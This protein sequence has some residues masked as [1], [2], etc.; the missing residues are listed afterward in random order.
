MLIVVFGAW[1]GLNKWYKNNL[2]P[3]SKTQSR[4]KVKVTPGLN[5]E[6]IGELL[7]K[8]GV[9]RSA[10]AFSWYTNGS[11]Q[12]NK[13]Q[14]GTY[15]FSPSQP[16]ETIADWLANGKTNIFNVII[17]P[18][19]TI[20]QL[21]NQLK[22]DGFKEKEINQALN[23]NYQSPILSGKPKGASLEGYLFPDTYKIDGETSLN[24]LFQKVFN[25]FWQQIKQN[26]LETKFKKHGLSVRQAVILAS[27]IQKEDSNPK[28]QPKI[29]QVF[30]KRLNS[31]IP[32]GSDVTFIYAAKLMG[33][34]ATP[35]LHS[36]YNTRIVKGLPPGPIANFNLSALKA[37]ANPASTDYLYFVA[38]DNGQVY[39]A[40]TEVEHQQNVDNYCHKLCQ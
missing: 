33:V 23:A 32:L 14:A 37:V 7:Q 22:K 6:Q 4:I 34:K 39:F 10:K 26:N 29:A 36:P 27:I 24:Q 21:K 17:L 38:G 18:G 8:H 5:A 28:I 35:D 40:K 13:L 2:K 3:L 25:N 11:G 12:R 15:L 31:N 20:S 19:Q 9:I 1:F 30:Y 16:V